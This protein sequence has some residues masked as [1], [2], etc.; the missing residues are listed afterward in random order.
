[1]QLF[2]K[3]ASVLN[4]TKFIFYHRLQMFFKIFIKTFPKFCFEYLLHLR[5]DMGCYVRPMHLDSMQ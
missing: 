2:G 3:L 5:S 1:M 4:M